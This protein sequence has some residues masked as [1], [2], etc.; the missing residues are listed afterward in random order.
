MHVEQQD[1]V[2]NLYNINYASVL[3]EELHSCSH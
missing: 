3:R 2:A 1:D